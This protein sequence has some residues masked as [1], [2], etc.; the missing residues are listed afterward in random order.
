MDNNHVLYW[1]HTEVLELYGFAKEILGK[2]SIFE[3]LR[4]VRFYI[5]KCA[6][7]IPQIKSLDEFD[8]VVETNDLKSYFVNNKQF[9]SM[10]LVLLS[11]AI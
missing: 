7:L 11:S 10:N 5:K 9:Y 3:L 2:V 8:F 4:P 1:A 6:R